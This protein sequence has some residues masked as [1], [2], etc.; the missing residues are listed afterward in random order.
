[1]SN[2]LASL[3][4]AAGDGSNTQSEFNMKTHFVYI[5]IRIGR[6]EDRNDGNSLMFTINGVVGW[7]C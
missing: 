2:P 4:A 3:L 6:V 1:M 5:R 7:Y